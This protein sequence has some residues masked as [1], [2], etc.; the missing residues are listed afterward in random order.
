MSLDIIVI[1][2]ILD[3]KASGNNPG[4]NLDFYFMRSL[5]GECIIIKM[6]TL[7]LMGL[8]VHALPKETAD[9]IIVYFDRRC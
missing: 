9:E 2:F 7:F 4:S 1:G 5:I 8:A 6:I 3:P